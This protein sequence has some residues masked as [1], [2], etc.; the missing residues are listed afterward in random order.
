MKINI[1]VAIFFISIFVFT[2][3][4]FAQDEETEVKTP[5]EFPDLENSM[6]ISIFPKFDIALD[7]ALTKLPEEAKS[8]DPNIRNLLIFKMKVRWPFKENLRFSDIQFLSTYFEQKVKTNF[9]KNPRFFFS[10]GQDLKTLTFSATDSTLNVKNTLSEEELKVY[11]GNRRI[12]ATIT[13]DV[14]ITPNQLVIFINV[15]D[16]N[17]IT[18]WSRE[19]K[20]QYRA[21]PIDYEKDLAQQYALKKFTGLVE[22]YFTISF[23]SGNVWRK[24]D[25]DTTKLNAL[26]DPSGYMPFFALGYRFNEV[27][28]IVDFLKFNFDTKM[29]STFKFGTMGLLLSPGVSFEIIGNETVGPGILLLD[30]NGGMYLSLKGPL[31]FFYGGGLTG[32][33]SRNLGISTYWQ[34]YPVKRTDKWDLGGPAFGFQ[35]F[36]VM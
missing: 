18:V 7:S 15:N 11:A 13:S 30:V 10:S 5:Q 8:I 1:K 6:L 25:L 19:F 12:D 24:D 29:V 26:K 9:T 35:V 3:S 34:Y 22:D 23:M 17:G 27:A 21:L 28:T 14:L 4:S 20:A 31:R 32:R 33:L 16:L 2:F 36:F